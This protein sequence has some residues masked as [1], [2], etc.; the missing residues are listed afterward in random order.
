MNTW[1]MFSDIPKGV[2]EL[3]RKLGTNIFPK[4]A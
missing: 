2:A 3:D 1:M 4:I